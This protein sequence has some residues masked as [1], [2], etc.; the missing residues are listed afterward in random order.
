MSNFSKFQTNSYCVGGRHYCGTNNIRGVVTAKG[1][2]MLKCHCTKCRRNKSMT[3]YDAI[4]EAEGL[5]EF[6]K[7]V[8]RATINF[9]K[10]VAN[11]PVRVLEIASKM[12]AAAA[13][14]NL[15]CSLVSN[16]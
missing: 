13:S 14:R 4:I 5:E 11:K 7:S 2:K 10:K 6:F 1:T 8:G 16:T 15:Q 12:G 3:V 9:G